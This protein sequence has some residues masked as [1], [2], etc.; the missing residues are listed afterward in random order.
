MKM[1]VDNAAPASGSETGKDAQE[2]SGTDKQQD[3]ADA[4]AESNKP[5]AEKSE[6]EK[7][8]EQKSIDPTKVLKDS[9]VDTTDD[10]AKDAAGKDGKGGVQDVK[11]KVEGTNA[12]GDNA[13]KTSAFGLG[14]SVGVVSNTNNANVAIDKNV[15]I[16]AAPV[17]GSKT[18][19]GSVNINARS[20]MTA[21]TE[22]EDSLQFSVKNAL[23][24][25]KVEI[26]AAVL[27]SNVKNNA[28]VLLDSDGEKSAQI[29]GIEVSLDAL[30]GMGK[31]ERPRKKKRGKTL[32]PERGLVRKAAE[33]LT[34]T[35]K[36]AVTLLATL[37]AAAAVL[38][39]APA[40]RKAA[41]L[42]ARPMREPKRR[43][44]RRPASWLIR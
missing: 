42:R 9:S 13:Q 44:K 22:A 32:A 18:V 21:S 2:A 39:P 28:T 11:D 26:G 4:N 41:D 36:A 14:A 33:A 20:M 34:V 30:A 10:K 1:T 38:M 37:R 43:S 40:A 16:T 8:S 17:E 27:V 35:R 3:N 31:Y 12:G 29:E 7:Q 15:V 5:D 25:A 19:D 24:N 6:D 23:S